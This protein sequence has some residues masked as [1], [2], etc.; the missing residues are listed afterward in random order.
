MIIN[1][2][3]SER[4]AVLNTAAGM[5]CAARTAPKT[6][7]VDRLNTL[8]LA[9]SD[10]FKLAKHMENIGEETGQA[11]F[12]R[13]AK[14]LKACIGVVLIAV[15]DRPSGLGEIC[16]YCGRPNCE[17]A[18]KEGGHCALASVDLGIAVGS[19]VSLAADNRVDNRVLFSA[20]RAAK[21]L[22]FFGN[23]YNQIIAIALACEGKNPLFDRVEQ[24]G[25]LTQNETDL[26]TS[27]MNHAINKIL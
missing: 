13:D 14:I 4:T 5:A 23:K 10:V 8:I 20:G 11:F 12:I 26:N 7:G 18:T 15:D 22:G 19:A 24:F 3:E 25:D 9:D 6:R 17:A 2:V 16:G 27:A 21:D 1:S